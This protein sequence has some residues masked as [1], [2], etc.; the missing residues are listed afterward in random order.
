MTCNLQ[1]K[2]HWLDYYN[3]SW[4]NWLNK[5][6]YGDLQLGFTLAQ[7]KN[8]PA[9]N[10]YKKQNFI[11]SW[12]K[13]TIF[14]YSEWMSWPYWIFFW[15]YVSLR[16]PTV[17]YRHPSTV[18]HLRITWMDPVASVINPTIITIKCQAVLCSHLLPIPSVNRLRS[19]CVRISNTIWL[20]F[21]IYSTIKS[22]RTPLL[23]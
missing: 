6:Y 4:N 15:V 10:W 12:W 8:I 22:K 21:P 2:A 19:R 11:I 18:I 16:Y 23:R 3:Y 1:S 7:T 17:I 9:S 13:L 5:I 14:W 20:C